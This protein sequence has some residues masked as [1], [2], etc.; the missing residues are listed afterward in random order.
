MTKRRLRADLP[1]RPF[2]SEVTL[3]RRLR[4]YSERRGIVMETSLHR[5]GSAMR[6]VVRMRAGKKCYAIQ[7]FAKFR[8][9]TIL[10]WSRQ[11]GTMIQLHF[12]LVQ[13]F[14]PAACMLVQGPFACLGFMW[15]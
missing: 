13:K 1:T 3:K 10:A 5:D 12:E 7:D 11:S 8:S 4:L 15:G 6:R 9:G 14:P 2:G